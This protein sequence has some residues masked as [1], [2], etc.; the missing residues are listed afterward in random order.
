M[1]PCWYSK[2]GVTTRW[3]PVMWPQ[4]KQEKSCWSRLSAPVNSC[5]WRT[6]YLASLLK[7]IAICVSKF[8]TWLSAMIEIRQMIMFV[9]LES[10]VNWLWLLSLAFTQWSTLL[11]VTKSEK[12]TL[13]CEEIFSFFLNDWIFQVSAMAHSNYLLNIR[14]Y[15]DHCYKIFCERFHFQN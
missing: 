14:R 11:P 2:Q 4:L 12:L 5:V 15:T 1:L 13:K 8:C 6:R 9:G 7:S 10:H 3:R